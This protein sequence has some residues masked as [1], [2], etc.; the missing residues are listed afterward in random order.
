MIIF[1]YSLSILAMLLIPVIL[2][3]LLRRKFKVPW[4]LF[5]VG[6]LTFIGSQVVH[7]PLNN[8][9]MSLNLLPESGEMDSF[10]LLKTALLLGLTAGLCEELARAAGY[11]LLK[12]YRRFEHG[13]MLGLGHG[14]IEAMVFG[15]VLT[16]AAIS[17]LLALQGTDLALL[18]LSGEQMANLLRQMQVFEQPALF[19]VAPLF[20]RLMAMTIHV[21]LSMIVLQAFVRRN[22]AYVVLAIL[23]HAAIDGLVGYLSFQTE[24]LLIIFGGLVAVVIPGAIWLWKTWPK[25]LPEDVRQV[26]EAGREFGVFLVACRKEIM[27]LW[28]TKRFLVVAAVFGLFGLTSP[29]LAYFM[30]QIFSSIDGAEMFAELIPTPTVKD[31]MDQYV[32]N[33]TQFGFILA[34]VFGMSAVVGEKEKGTTAMILSKPMPRWAFITSKFVAQSVMYVVGFLVATFGAYFYTLVLFGPLNFFSFL[35][36]N[37]LM[38]LWLLTYVALA[39]LGSVIGQSTPAA[40]GIGLGGAV[41]LM[42]AANLPQ[43]GGLT[44]TGLIGWASQI[45]AGAENIASNGGAIAMGLVIIIMC[46]I[47]SVG[48]FEHQEL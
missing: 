44:P 17:S 29:L 4:L 13:I 32:K 11:W 38:L 41:I 18:N 3:V 20:E 15:G 24:N 8:A 1:A 12:R 7:I 31:A 9:L 39:L 34:I 6:T 30:P 40:A 19:A 33:I 14:G 10:P 35:A 27:Q 37:A 47:A 25:Q 36:V 43:V 46:L 23:Y 22:A 28:R 16:A 48:L 21:V 26:P 45:A 2:A 5:A 42:L